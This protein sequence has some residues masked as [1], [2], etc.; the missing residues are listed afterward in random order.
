MHILVV[1][2]YIPYPIDRGTYQRVFHLLRE[3]AKNH[4]IDLIALSEKGERVEHRSVFE[5]FCRKVVFVPFEHPP[6][7]S[8]FPNR[9][10]NSLPTTIRHWWL[11]QLADTIGNML[12]QNEYDMVHVCDIVMAQ[13]FLKDH[14]EI[15]LSVDR[16]RVDLQFQEEQYARMPKGIKSSLLYREQAW[17]LRRL[18]EEGFDLPD[19]LRFVPIDFEAGHDWWAGLCDAGFAPDRP[20]VVASTGVSMYLTKDTTAATLRRL[21]TL[22]SGS[23]VAM[24]FLLPPELLDEAD[25]AGLEASSRGARASGTPFISFYRPAEIVALADAAGF[26]TVEPISSNLLIDRYF[27]DQA[28][29]L[30]PSSGEALIASHN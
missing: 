19:R 15:P 5:S 10:L 23:V 26:R 28:D 12:D 30:R 7:P 4:T 25:R 18:V 13:Y 16:S 27:A 8:L 1:Y 29:G 24:S 14:L 20:A 22:A 17:K 2:P 6:W 3:L 21:A 11:P 9:L